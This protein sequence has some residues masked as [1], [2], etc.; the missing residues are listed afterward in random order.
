M[1]NKASN[2]FPGRCLY[3]HQPAITIDPNAESFLCSVWIGPWPSLAFD[4]FDIRFLVE[5][6]TPM[7]AP[8]PAAAEL[9]ICMRILSETDR[10]TPK[11]VDVM[12]EDKR[13]VAAEYCS[14]V[15]DAAN[16][17][18]LEIAIPGVKKEDIHLR[19]KDDSFHLVAS[20]DDFDYVTASAFCC[21]VKAQSAQAKYEDGLLRITLDFKDPMEDAFNVTIV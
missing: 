17:L 9:I 11:E 12:S 15:D 1:R 8:P 19:V 18:N 16:A 13:R 3:H 21:P 7:S 2:S 6:E 5:F 14:Y 4:H 20:R 10:L